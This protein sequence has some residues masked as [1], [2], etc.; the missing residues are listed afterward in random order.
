MNLPRE[1]FQ[2]AAAPAVPQ[3]M[4]PTAPDLGIAGFARLATAKIG[5]AVD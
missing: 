1:A 2:P 5:H 4:P 3:A